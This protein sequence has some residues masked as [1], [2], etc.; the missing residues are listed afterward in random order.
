MVH[1]CGWN[2]EFS[3]GS[4]ILSTL[5]DHLNGPAF[6]P[7]LDSCGGEH[8]NGDCNGGI[9]CDRDYSGDVDG[10]GD[11]DGDRLWWWLP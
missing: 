6:G 4:Q 1:S 7:A 8:R 3:V 2:F 11:G 9:G 10:D 5:G